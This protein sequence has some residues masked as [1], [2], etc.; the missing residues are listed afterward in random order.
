MVEVE[1]P[2]CGEKYSKLGLHWFKSSSCS[3]P[4]FSDEQYEIITGVVMGDGCVEKRN[5]NPNLQCQMISREYLKYLDRKFGCFSRGVTLHRTSEEGYRMNK[6]SG[7]SPNAVKKDY[8]DL[9]RWRSRSHPNLQEFS[10]W[11]STGKKVWPEDIEL[12]PTVLKHWY[13]GDGH[14]D[15]S[16]SHNRIKISMN[17]ESENKNKV[18]NIFQD[19]GLPRPSNYNE[20]QRNC[21]AV[22]T[23]DQSHRLWEYMGDPLPDF[24][25]KWPPEYR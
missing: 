1:C 19:V 9:Y 13:C 6:E 24:E 10:D 25:Y 4:D 21:L 22:F 14:W 3:F 20:S 12:T 18:G 8:S 11:Y 23:A 7:F 5:K 2:T 17:N 16:D 15:N